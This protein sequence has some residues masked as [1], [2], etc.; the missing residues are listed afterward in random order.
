MQDYLKLVWGGIFSLSSVLII[1]L[2]VQFRY[3]KIEAEKL[4][5]LQEEYRNYISAIKTVY[6]DA[7]RSCEILAEE[8]DSDEKKKPFVVVERG[9]QHLRDSV[10]NYFMENNLEHKLKELD[11]QRQPIL[12]RKSP[13]AKKV[14]RRIF[15]PSYRSHI[16]K[17]FK[18]PIAL[19]DFWISSLFGKRKKPAGFHSGI[20]MAAMK[21][22][23][24]TAAD[25]GK[26]IDA[27]Y[28]SGFGNMV[29]IQHDSKYK[30]RYAH[31][32]KILVQK[33]D[34]ISAGQKIGTVGDTGFVRSSGRDASH[35]H[36]EVYVFDKVINPLYVLPW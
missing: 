15:K 11:A 29:F 20:D 16:E 28:Y 26:V 3:L 32:N 23:P 34:Q 14:A 24:V 7:G 30:T 35:L 8:Q 17:R 1:T 22:T 13:V 18:W 33:G 5:D 4:S 12:T 25:S 10:V 6:D 21:N 31:L 9:K 27:G 2:L 36:F 19:K